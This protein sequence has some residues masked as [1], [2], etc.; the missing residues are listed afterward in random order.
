MGD[1]D[2]VLDL[3][4]ESV[5]RDPAVN[6]VDNFGDGELQFNF[7]FLFEIFPLLPVLQ[8]L[9]KHVHLVEVNISLVLRVASKHLLR[10]Q[11]VFICNVLFRA[12]RFQLQQKEARQNQMLHGLS[13]HRL[14]LFH[15]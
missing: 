6:K 9:P 4:F 13:V 14:C 12:G 7:A 8:P 1:F 3:M 11:V 2:P 5:K 15:T 10:F